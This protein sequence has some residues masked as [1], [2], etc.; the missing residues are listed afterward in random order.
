MPAYACI[1]PTHNRPDQ[2]IAAVE[3]VLAQTD[4]DLECIV[5]D[6]GSTDDTPERL[7]AIDDARLRIERQPR[8]GVAA[9]RN[10]GVALASSPWIAFLDSDDLWEPQKME[11]QRAHMAAHRDLRISQTDEIWIRR[12]VRVNPKNKHRKRGGDLFE[13]SLAMCVISPSAVMLSRE[14]WNDL[15]GFDESFPACED[16][17]LW[18]RIAS[19]E[20]VGYL[21][22]PLVIKYGGHAD[23]L[24]RTVPVLDRW[25]IRAIDKLLASGHL[26]E[27]QW[28]AAVAE[29]ERKCRIVA[30]G[31]RKR[32]KHDEAER[33]LELARR[34]NA[35]PPSRTGE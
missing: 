15:G 13:R 16:Y 18:L 7:D 21:D 11:R 34:R 17:D 5:V 6:D 14:L 26:D 12:G 24:S 3:S 1:I 29:L 33:V 8:R 23:Q 31:C 20:P 22:E 35:Q 10:R 32:G 4:A 28:R 9:A 27:R 2:T 19:R 30:L 25:R